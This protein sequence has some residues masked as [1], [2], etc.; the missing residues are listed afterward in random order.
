MIFYVYLHKKNSGEVFY[1][2]KGCKDRAWSHRDRSTLW[3]RV[4]KK[5]G[6]IVEVIADKLTEAQ[7]FSL[8]V[9]TIAAYGRDNLCNFTDG[10]DGVSGY[11]HTDETRKRMARLR[12]GKHH[13]DETRRKIG[14]ANS[15]RPSKWLGKSLSEEHKKAVGLSMRGA[16]NG[17]YNHSRHRFRHPDVGVVE[18]TQNELIS[19][20]G[21]HHGAVSGLVSGKVRSVKGWAIEHGPG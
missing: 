15:G 10:G 20:Y 13:S 21:L 4:V 11:R 5:H 2:G 16:V 12:V 17:R 8:E 14:E 9:E 18:M 19:A 7:A 1:V 6:L 3:Q